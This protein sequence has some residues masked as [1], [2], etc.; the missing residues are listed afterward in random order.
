MKTNPY[1]TEEARERFQQHLPLAKKIAAGFSNTPRATREEIEAAAIEALWRAVQSFEG[2][3]GTFEGYAVTV[4]QNGL[5]DLYRKGSL[6][7]QRTPL[8]EPSGGGD[9]PLPL[10]PASSPSPVLEQIARSETG[11]HLDAILG[12]MD[13]R[14]EEVLRRTA[15]GES[16]SEI[17]ASLGVSKQM[18]SKILSAARLDAQQ[19]IQTKGLVHEGAT[20]RSQGLPSAAGSEAGHPPAPH[21]SSNEP[22]DPQKE[23]EP[24]PKPPGFWERIRWTFGSR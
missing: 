9:H 1:G 10:E 12:A 8:M 18:V 2:K 13:P 4:I 23:P 15:A 21:A 16:G 24:A 20:L 22:G 5:K 3:E 6:L 17:A 14:R 11:G 19:R 7:N